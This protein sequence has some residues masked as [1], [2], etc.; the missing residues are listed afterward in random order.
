MASFSYNKD[1][2]NFYN[3]DYSKPG[4]VLIIN[5]Q[6]FIGG[7]ERKGSEKDVERILGTFKILNFKPEPFRNQT[8]QQIKELIENYSNKDYSNDS[9][10]ICFIMSHGGKNGKVAAF[11]F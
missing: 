8:L 9:C 6:N 1:Y 3:I 10:F 4:I 2:S 7:E 5:N 11:F